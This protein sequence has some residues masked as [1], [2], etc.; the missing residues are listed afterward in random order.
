MRVRCFRRLRTRRAG[1]RRRRSVGHDTAAAP[2]AAH[3][4]SCR[5]R[6]ATPWQAAETTRE[7]AFTAFV[8]SERG[9]HRSPIDR[10]ERPTA[11]RC[12]PRRPRRVRRGACAPTPRTCWRA[13]D[14]WARYEREHPGAVVSAREAV[15][16]LE[17][18]EAER[19]TTSR[20]IEVNQL[21][22]LL[23]NERFKWGVSDGN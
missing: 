8:H 21:I 10:N 3:T 13:Y 5:R 7:E 16:L 6:R 12:Q 11:S 19:G 4:S 14:F 1:L 17:R 23:L 22:D 18:Q 15:G 20:S 2:N 9:A